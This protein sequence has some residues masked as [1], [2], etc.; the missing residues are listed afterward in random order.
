VSAGAPALGFFLLM[1]GKIG[2]DTA[3]YFGRIGAAASVASAS[4]RLYTAVSA[5]GG[6]DGDSSAG[7]FD[8][9]L[10]SMQFTGSGLLLLSTFIESAAA[11]TFASLAG[12][13]LGILVLE[14]DLLRKTDAGFDALFKRS[15][16]AKTTV[17]SLCSGAEACMFSEYPR[18]LNRRGLEA[19]QIT[20]QFDA[21]KSAL[22]AA[23]FFG[24]PPLFAIDLEN[25][26]TT[27]DITNYAWFQS[28]VDRVVEAQWKIQKAWRGSA[29]Y[30]HLADEK[31]ARDGCL[32]VLKACHIPLTIAE[33][34]LYWDRTTL[35]SQAPG[36][37]DFSPEIAK[38]RDAI[39]DLFDPRRAIQGVVSPAA[40]G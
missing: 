15:A 8:V 2:D 10:A 13:I 29:A 30:E 38:Q 17:D 28:E 31:L 21:L 11:R 4:V 24:M 25:P 34:L 3:G 20:A 7:L 26:C 18:V 27:G 35:E 39:D 36:F 37:L 22:G 32:A 5:L 40:D 6:S 14:A 1:K 23:Q 19:A 33:V 9:A 16:P 12:G